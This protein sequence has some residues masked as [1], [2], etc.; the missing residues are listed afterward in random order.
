VGR[1]H[2]RR[3]ARN[4]RA[5]C[6]FTRDGTRVALSGDLRHLTGEVLA[7]KDGQPMERLFPGARER[8]P[9][10]PAVANRLQILDAQA[11]S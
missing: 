8:K 9:S 3:S 5:W 7:V 1:P 6:A 4:A 10:W 11:R 2:R